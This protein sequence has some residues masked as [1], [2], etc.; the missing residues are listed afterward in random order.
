MAG[1]VVVCILFNSKEYFGIPKKYQSDADD[2]DKVMKIKW[3]R[4][5]N[6]LKKNLI[7]LE[8]SFF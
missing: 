3:Q 8:V 5:K 7:F 4:M 2:A 6:F 1:P